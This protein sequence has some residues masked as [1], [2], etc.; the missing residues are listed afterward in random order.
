MNNLVQRILTAT[1]LVSA[2]LFIIF[3]APD[4]GFISF[5]IALILLCLFELLK[6]VQT[7]LSNKI[8]SAVVTLALGA[9]VL[10]GV[11]EFSFA[12]MVFFPLAFFWWL[13][14]LW[15]VVNYPIRKPNNKILFI[16]ASLGLSPLFGLLFLRHIGVEFLLLLLLLV[17][18]ADIFA[19]V[20]G[21]AFGKHK[22][23]PK[24]SAGKTIEGV[25]GGLLACVIITLIWLYVVD[26]AYQQYY[27]Y[28]LLAMITAL[29]SVVGDLLLSIYKREAGVK[30]S[31]KILPGH[32][33]IL[34]R[35]DGLLAATPIFITGIFFL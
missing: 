1:V 5:I 15:M 30:N 21:S 34:D 26:I 17:W 22:L 18:G 12:L 35:V 29:F 28:L 27:K 13:I 10:F 3:K 33:G 25:L 24:L 7:N 19:Y 31:G 6:L 14:N 20:F 11:M 23:A 32:G 2:V 8:L 4:A 9:F 16:N